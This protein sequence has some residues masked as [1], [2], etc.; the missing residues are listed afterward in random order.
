MI[1]R[2][3]HGRPDLID[4]RA[5][6]RPWQASGKHGSTWQAS[7]KLGSTW[8]ACGKLYS[9]SRCQPSFR[10]LARA[11][12]D[13]TTASQPRQASPLPPHTP[14]TSQN[15][16]LFGMPSQPAQDTAEPS[17]SPHASTTRPLC[18]MPSQPASQSITERSPRAGE[19]LLSSYVIFYFLCRK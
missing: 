6:G 15:L 9:P 5:H 4:R 11:L 17:H 12:V 19:L 7:G 10:V 14:H 3:A 8:Q 1:D 18:A 13:S 2:R 16:P